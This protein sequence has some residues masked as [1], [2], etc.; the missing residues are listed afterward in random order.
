METSGIYGLGKLLGHRCV[1]FNA[2][3]VN[4]KLGQFSEHPDETI[5]R[6]I[7]LILERIGEIDG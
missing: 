6:L 1:S 4:R 2:M 7:Q 3:V 5:D